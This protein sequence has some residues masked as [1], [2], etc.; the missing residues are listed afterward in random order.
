MS[1]S[2]SINICRIQLAGIFE[3]TLAHDLLIKFD[4]IE[5]IMVITI[6]VVAIHF[7]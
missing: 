6:Q 4:H 7:H 3:K 2:K 1:S 5:G